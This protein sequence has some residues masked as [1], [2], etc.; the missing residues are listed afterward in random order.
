VF[1]LGNVQI[2][3]RLPPNIHQ[4]LEK[5]RKRKGRLNVQEIIRDA[6]DEYLE[7][8]ALKEVTKRG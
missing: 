4:E 7:R 8:E 5:V 1:A 2:C 3:L 6:I